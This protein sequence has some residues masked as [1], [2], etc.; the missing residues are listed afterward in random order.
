MKVNQ[1]LN[2]P[3]ICNINPR[4][5]YNKQN[6][7][8]TFVEEEN[9]DLILMSESWER[10][11]LT[12]DQLIHLPNHTIISN[13]NQ[14]RGTGGRPAIFANNQ[15]FNV[16][17]ITNTLIQVPWG[18]EAI[19]CILSPKNTTNDSEIQRI[20]CCALYSK[21]DSR[22][23]SLLLDHISEVYNILSTKYGRGLHFVIGGDTNDLKLDSIL[24]LDRRFVQVVQK[25]TRLNPPAILDPVIMTLS[26]YYQEPLCLEPLDPDP[27]KKGAKSDHRIVLIVPIN[28][29]NNKS[30]R[31]TREIRV[32]PFPQ[33]GLLK[34]KDWIM[35]QSW[36]KVFGAESAHKKAEVFQYILI[37][38]LEEIF[39]E[40]T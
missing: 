34:F 22:K 38:K 25:W 33:S 1:A 31:N 6:E 19:W 27:E 2:L 36:D 18:V 26:K 37:N 9:C 32:R 5:I 17:N 21:P 40:K 30:I 7:F 23:K 11:Y 4:S 12:L 35:N 28:T 29:I 13:V 15:K 14:R 16:E 8:E 24:S 20:V 10:D 3:V 39:P